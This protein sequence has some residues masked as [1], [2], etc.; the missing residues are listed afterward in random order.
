M[1]RPNFPKRVV[2]TG[3]MPYGSKELHFGHIGGVFVHADVFAR[4]MKDRIGEENVIFVSGTDCYGSPIVEKYRTLVAD[5]ECDG[6]IIDF[7]Q[8]NHN[9]QRDTLNNYLIG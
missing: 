6:S 7:V 8:K 3:G 9:S 2:I 4:F 1:E 5:G